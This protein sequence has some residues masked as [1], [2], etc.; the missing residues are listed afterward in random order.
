MND[1]DLISISWVDE[2]SRCFDFWV[3]D[4]DF[5]GETFFKDGSGRANL[6]HLPSP[7]PPCKEAVLALGGMTI[8]L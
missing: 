2:P 1:S 6:N 4:P 5:E 3:D 7:F 8:F